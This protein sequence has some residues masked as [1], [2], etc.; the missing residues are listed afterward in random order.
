MEILNTKN[1][2]DLSYQMLGF[3]LKLYGLQQ[4][5]QPLEKNGNADL[6][7]I[8]FWNITEIELSVSSG[9]VDSL[10]NGA[11][12]TGSPQEKNLNDI[13]ILN[14]LSKNLLQIVEILK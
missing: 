2:A 8:E 13:T 14:C 10:I 11:G 12:K 1:K 4:W 6:H 7:V 3:L 9:K 5:C